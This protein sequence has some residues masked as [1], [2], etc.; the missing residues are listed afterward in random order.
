MDNSYKSCDTIFS[1]AVRK[2]GATLIPK[3]LKDGEYVDGNDLAA[4]L[5]SEM[6]LGLAEREMLA[7]LVTGEFQRSRGGQPIGV[8]SSRIAPSLDLY[9]EILKTVKME[10]IAFLDAKTHYEKR[11]G[12]ISESQFRDWI[13]ERKL[14]EKLTPE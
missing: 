10:K 4:L 1:Y 6:D 11:H 8:G 3:R 13:A 5:R 14:R 12:K 7:Q 9:F 2:C